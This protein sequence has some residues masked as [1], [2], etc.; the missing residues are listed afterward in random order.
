MKLD[1][2]LNYKVERVKPDC[3]V[4]FGDLK[5][6]AI[7]YVGIVDK[8][9]IEVGYFYGDSKPKNI[10][11]TSSQVGCPS[12]CNFCEL[13]NES[14]GRN[15][16]SEEMYEEVVL[17]L[18]IAYKHGVL[19]EQPHKINWSKSGDPLFNPNFV[20][21]LEKTSSF[22]FSHKVSTVFPYNTETIQ[23][24]HDVA[25]FDSQYTEPIQ[26]QISLISTNE[27]YRRKTARIQVA[28]LLQIQKAADYWRKTNPEGRKINL[29]LILT[30]DVPVNVLDVKGILPPDQ[31][32]F[33]F[34]NYVKTDNGK[35]HRLETITK[36]R[37]QEIFKQFQDEG[38][39]VGT[40]ATPTPMEK[41]F[42]LASNVTLRRYKQMIEGKL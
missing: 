17:M 13:G 31:F 18:Q 33:R 15:L 35:T 21:A 3:V 1:S 26:I 11:V 7:E 4:E 34:R 10:I 6:G 14:F 37:Y 23:R 36:E 24:F 29:S 28:T 39:D 42:G 9:I 16:T 32:R 2:V 12:K 30:N 38:Y 40:W 22:R 8:G 19:G 27:E 25:D 5:D 20:D 41:K